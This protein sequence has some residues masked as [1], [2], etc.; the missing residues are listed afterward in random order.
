MSRSF[1]DVNVRGEETEFYSGIDDAYRQCS[2][3]QKFEIQAIAGSTAGIPSS[4]CASVGIVQ[5][6]LLSSDKG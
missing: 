2:K 3:P 5:C 6:H 4:I 1:R